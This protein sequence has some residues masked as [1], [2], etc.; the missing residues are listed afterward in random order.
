MRDA[1][2]LT[3]LPKLVEKGIE[4]AAHDPQGK[5]EAKRVA[6]KFCIY[7]QKKSNKKW[8]QTDY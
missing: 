1:P 4:I 8:Q 2:S 7:S 3:I 5:E 6:E